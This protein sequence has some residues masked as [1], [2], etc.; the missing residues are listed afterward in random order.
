MSSLY[1]TDLDGT[2]LTDNGTISPVTFSILQNLLE[3][4][5]LFTTASARSVASIQHIFKGLKF[6]L[7]VIEFNGAIISDLQSGQHLFISSIDPPLVEDI[8]CVIEKYG[9]SPFVSAYTGV[10]DRLYY[11]SVTN[12]GVKWYLNDRKIQNDKR[13]RFVDK[14]S[15]SFADQVICLNVIG[16]LEVL[17]DLESELRERYRGSLEIH[18]L[19]DHYSPGFFW[20]TAHDKKATKDNAIKELQQITGLSGSEVVVFG[21][22]A[23]DIGMFKIADRSIAVSNAVEELKI[24]A[25]HIIGS[26]SEDSV[27]RFIQS[28]ILQR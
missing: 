19:E 12:D 7:P 20:L 28:D 15:S 2:L 10:E 11:S 16:K 26:N 22:N 18:C 4:G 24:H 21:D 17:T 1:I 23:N 27:A 5:I 8:C 25:T 14:I 13:L 6:D 9:C 3:K